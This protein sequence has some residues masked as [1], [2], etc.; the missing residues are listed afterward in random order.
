MDCNPTYVAVEADE[1]QE[2]VGDIDPADLS[3]LMSGSAPIVTAPAS[4]DGEEVE[5]EDDRV[6]GLFKMM[7]D[8]LENM[9]ELER[10]LRDLTSPLQGGT[11]A[12]QPPPDSEVNVWDS[13]RSWEKEYK[14][15]PNTSLDDLDQ[16]LFDQVYN[17]L[18]IMQ[19]RVKHHTWNKEDRRMTEGL[20]SILVIHYRCKKLV[21]KVLR[22]L[23][24]DANK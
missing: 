22:D 6:E 20:N 14:L 4:E 24:H 15:F 9:E 2:D 18:S 19:N 16:C 7:C 12:K 13:G 3:P 10:G 11:W 21:E 5:Y 23:D 1:D 8:A 17:L